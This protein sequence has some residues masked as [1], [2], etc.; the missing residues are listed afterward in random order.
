MVWHQSVYVM[1]LAD[2]RSNSEDPY[3]FTSSTRQL[4]IRTQLVGDRAGEPIENFM[5]CLPDSQVLQLMDAEAVQPTCV[6]ITIVDDDCKL[7]SNCYINL[8][9]LHMQLFSIVIAVVIGFR[10]SFEVVMEGGTKTVCAYVMP[11]GLRL[12]PFDR[13]PLSIQTNPGIIYRHVF[14]FSNWFICSH[15]SHCSI[16]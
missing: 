14:C 2:Y 13:V 3:V 10:N 16:K 5:I 6:T 9:N 11:E 7:T 12:D 4:P 15:N 1:F 8:A